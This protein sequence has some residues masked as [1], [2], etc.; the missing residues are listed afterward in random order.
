M[1]ENAD[2]LICWKEYPH[3]DILERARELVEF[4]TALAE[5]RLKLRVAVVDTGMIVSLHTTRE[6]GKSFVNRVRALE[7]KDG[8]VSVSIVH[9]FA[10][11]DVPDMGTKVLAY[12]DRSVDRARGEE[13]AQRL[14]RELC[15]L[16]D[17][18]AEPLIGI[19]AA[20]DKALAT[21]GTV[22]LGDG[23][24]NPG[25]GAPGDSTYILGR[26]IERN[27]ASA[28]LGP[29]WDPGA[30]RI[31]FDA[32]VGARLALRIGGKIGPLSGDPV[33]AV[34]EI[35]GLKPDMVMT[36]LAGTPAKLGDCALVACNGVEVVLS[37][38][39]C[40]A[41]GVDVFTQLGVDPAQRKI[42]VVKSSQHFRASFEPIA[43]KVIMVD[44]PG[45]VARDI[46]TLPYRKIKRPKWPLDAS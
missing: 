1:V 41:F 46:T 9:G 12:S 43:A 29:L 21:N 40:Q 24:D 14:A 7:G 30:V 31:A 16:R 25:G 17:A 13:V 39:R 6:P 34:W 4:C 35:R 3:T 8:I 45:V 20:L 18:L 44:V 19:D 32:G 5:E 27:V 42:V 26:L 10:W 22:V 23:N 11:G 15:D 37:T 38:Y 28:C 33:D 2:L 36:G